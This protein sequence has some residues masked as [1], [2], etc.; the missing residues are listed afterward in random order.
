MSKPANRMESCCQRRSS[1]S[2]KHTKNFF[3][4]TLIAPLLVTLSLGGCFHDDDNAA[5]GANVFARA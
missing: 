4:L 5:P 1:G 2:D 3:G